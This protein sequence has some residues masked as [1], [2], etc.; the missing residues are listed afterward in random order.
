[1]GDGKGGGVADLTVDSSTSHERAKP[2]LSVKLVSFDKREYREGDEVE[3]AIR[4][5]NESATALQVPVLPRSAVCA[6]IVEQGR[7]L[8]HASVELVIGNGGAGLGLIGVV[9]LW[10]TASPASFVNLQPGSSAVLRASTI[11][12]ALAVPGG[13]PKEAH[14][15][16]RVRGIGNADAMSDSA[17]LRTAVEM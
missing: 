4:L 1:M 16:L 2:Q 11:W 5:T 17:L 3:F 13:L 10:Q 15:A 8:R 9:S 12:R 14:A 6:E 7:E